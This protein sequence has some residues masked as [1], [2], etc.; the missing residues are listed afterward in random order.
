HVTP[1]ELGGIGLRCTADL[2]A[3]DDQA[4]AVD[5]DS[6]LEATVNRVVLEHV[7]E[8]VDVEQIVD[9]HDLDVVSCNGCSEHHAADAAK[10]IDTDFDHLFYSFA[11]GRKSQLIDAYREGTCQKGPAGRGQTGS[12]YSTTHRQRRNIR[13]KGRALSASTARS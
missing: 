8:V 9:C 1:S 5:S 2:L 3:V 12:P 11:V 10:T 7:R 13:V 6:A 4:A